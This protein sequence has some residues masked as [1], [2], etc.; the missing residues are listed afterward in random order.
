[1]V[2][3]DQRH[4]L[5]QPLFARMAHHVVA[6]GCKP[7]AVW[8]PA[9]RQPGDRGEDVGVLGHLEGGHP[10]R[11]VLLD[12]LLGHRDRPPV[13]H[14]RRGDE[15]LA[16]LR[17]RQHGLVHLQRAA[18][19]DA[20]DTRRCGQG[21]RSGHER[22]L[23]TG[24]GAGPSDRKAHLAARQV[25]D[26]AHRVHGLEGGAGGH[27]HATAGQHLGLEEGD[28]RV[29]QLRGLEHAAIAE[30]AAGLR[31]VARPEQHCA[32]GHG[33]P[34]VALRGRVRPHLAVHRRGEEQG[35]RV[36]ARQR[37]RQAQQ[38]QQVVGAAASQGGD[39]VGTGRRDDDGIR[40]ARQVD[41]R[42]VAGRTRVPGAGVDVPAGERLHRHWR[43]E[44]LCSLGHHDLH[45][46]A[47]LDQFARQVSRLVAGDAAAQAEH[48]MAA[49]KIQPGL[50]AHRIPQPAP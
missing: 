19:V 30:L 5:A 44:L 49:G 8:P 40:L 21:H 41:M 27:Q 33:L 50:I 7:D 22:D 36:L 32:I 46:G 2:G 43:D 18:H 24:L 15:Q 23:R 3:H 34:R 17:P 42:H 35:A 48:E 1:M 38:R 4:A 11:A 20:L 26:P 9:C 31:A 13:G 47:G 28:D 10:A 39:E 29:A 6:L 25:G 12:L 14:R 37:T 16:R 45:R